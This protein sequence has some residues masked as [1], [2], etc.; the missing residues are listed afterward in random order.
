M[1]Q[2]Y[3]TVRNSVFLSCVFFSFIVFIK[4]SPNA[5]QELDVCLP[6]M[7]LFIYFHM[8]QISTL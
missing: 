6:F 7:Y 3:S 4:Q 1:N 5:G 2:K 8:N